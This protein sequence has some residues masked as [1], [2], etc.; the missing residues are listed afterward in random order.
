MPRSLG[1]RPRPGRLTAWL[2]PIIVLL[3]TGAIVLARVALPDRPPSA[4]PAEEESTPAPDLAFTETPTPTATPFVPATVLPEKRLEGADLAKAQPA[5]VNR[6][7]DGD[8]L[9]VTVDGTT[10]TVRLYG[11]D[12]PEARQGSQPEPCSAEATKQM[13]TLLPAGA[14]IL[15]LPD[16]RERDRYGRLLRYVFTPGGISLDAQMVHVGLAH[17]WRSDGSFKKQLREIEEDA[18]LHERGCLWNL[19]S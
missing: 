7:I 4:S 5:T 8:T 18:S 14:G 15:L 12:A 17:A 2:L 6:I 9:E 13:E 16:E 11:I 10:E 19:D 1:G 3:F